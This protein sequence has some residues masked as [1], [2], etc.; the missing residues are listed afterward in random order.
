MLT[1]HNPK[2]LRP[3]KFA[4]ALPRCSARLVPVPSLAIHICVCFVL[5]AVTATLTQADTIYRCGEAYSTSSQCDNAVASEVKPAPG[6]RSTGPN[7]NAALS[8]N[9]RDAQALE[10]QRLQLERQATFSAPIRLNTPAFAPA[11]TANTEPMVP[12]A[13]RHGPYGKKLQSPYFTAVAPSAAPQKK[14]TA[15]AVPEKSSSQP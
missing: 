1:Q 10:K 15:K 5:W 13:K 4:R 2:E 11:S 8:S 14:S 6:L 3:A 7:P 12:H 9:V